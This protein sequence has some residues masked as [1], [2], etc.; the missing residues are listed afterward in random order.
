MSSANSWV[1]AGAAANHV[2]ANWSSDFLETFTAED[3]GPAYPLHEELYELTIGEKVLWFF[4]YGVIAFLAVFGNLLV[5]YVV[6][7]CPR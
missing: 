7:T 1:V 4:V 3:S 5:I 6:F 2:V